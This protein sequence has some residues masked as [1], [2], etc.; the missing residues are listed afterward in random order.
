MYTDASGN[1]VERGPVFAF[2]THPQITSDDDAHPVTSARSIDNKIRVIMDELLVGNNLEEIECRGLVDEDVFDNVPLG[3]TP[4]DIARCAVPRDVLPTS[5]PQTFNKAVCICKLDAGCGDAAKGEPVGVLDVNQDGAGDNTRF[6]VGS[7]RLQCGTIDVPLDLNASYWNPSGDQNVPA[8]G[9]F[10]ALGPAIVMV[11]TFPAG[12]PMGTAAFLPTNTTCGLVFAESVTDKQ[13]NQV[14]APPDG[15]ITKTCTPGNTEAFSFKVEALTARLLGVEETGVPRT[16]PIPVK[17][18]AP[19][20]PA[21]MNNI[22]VLQG[23]TP[24]T[25]VT[26]TLTSPDTVRITPTAV[27]GFAADTQYTVNVP[28]TMTDYYKQPLPMPSTFTFT[29]GQ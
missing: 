29:T 19:L 15:D 2:G 18:S 9:G 27:G 26:L 21:T 8:M 7:V 28:T 10:E 16:M 13:G 3:A 23:T 4:D 22:T 25:Q 12:S 6:K 11:P 17:F 24:Y 14:C 5:C 20:D 1:L